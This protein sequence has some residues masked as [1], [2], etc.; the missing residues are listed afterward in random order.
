MDA[1]QRRSEF[2]HHLGERQSERGMPPNQHVI[3]AGMQARRT[4]EPDQLAQAS[5]YPVALHR[6]AD[7][8]RHRKTDTRRALIGTPTRLQHES[9]AGRPHS[10]GGSTKVRPA[11]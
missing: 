3:V 1:P 11:L 10:G 2:P 8:P 7:V 6:I 9:A 4:R 5:P